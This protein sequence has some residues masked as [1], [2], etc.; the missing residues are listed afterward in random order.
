VVGTLVESVEA[1][2]AVVVVFLG[3]RRWSVNLVA[4]DKFLGEAPDR[5]L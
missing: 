4:G 5:R 1:A 3:R 2:V